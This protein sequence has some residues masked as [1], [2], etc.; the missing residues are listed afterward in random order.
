MSD[1]TF[2]PIESQEAL[3]NVIKDRLNRQKSKHLEEVEQLNQQIE[4]L[5]ATATASE[6]V[7]KQLNEA[8]AK[9]ETYQ[10]QVTAFEKSIA[11]KDALISQHELK[12]T[13]TAVA[14]ETGLPLS[15]ADRLTG[16]TR[17]EILADAESML[18]SFGTIRNTA[19]SV[20]VESGSTPI[21]GVMAEFLKRNPNLKI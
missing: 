8:L 16:S 11:E 9:I 6:D 2:T 1:I 14:L 13:K 21:D 4:N 5:K 19:P 18:K 17:E 20:N 7:Q 15:L 10:G 12:A 3:D